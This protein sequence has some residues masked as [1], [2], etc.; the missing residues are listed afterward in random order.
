[1]FKKTAGILFVCLHCLITGAAQE[2]EIELDPVT[3]TSS[4]QQTK[5]SRTGRNILVIKGD[6]LINTPVHTIDDLLRYIPGIEVQARGP[7]GA[8]S[9]FTLRGGTFQ[10]VLV[11]LDGVRINDPNT[12]HF[13]S[14]L[15]IAPAEIERIEVLKGGSSAIYGSDAVGGVIHIISK[16]FAAKNK[17]ASREFVTQATVGEYDLVNVNAGGFYT[18][19]KTAVGGGILSNHTSGQ[20]QRGARGYVHMNSASLSL[21]HNINA[22]WQLGL[23]T[24]YDNRDFSAQ[25]FYTGRKVDTATEQVKSFWNQVRLSYQKSKSSFSLNAGYKA[26]EDNYQFNSVSVPN[27]NKSRLLQA[28]GVYEH[29]FSQ[30]TIVSTGIQY[31]NRVIRSNDRGN[32][33]V[34]QVAGFATINQLIGP[35]FQVNPA[36]R[37]DWHEL[38]GAELVPQINASYRLQSLQLRSSAG[39]TIRYADFTEQFNNYNKPPF[40][41]SGN[42]IGNPDLKAERSL[43]YEAGLDWYAANSFRFSATYFHRDYTKLIDYVLTPYEQ[44]PRKDNLAPNGSFYLASNISEVMTKGIEADIQYQKKLNDGQSL[45]AGLGIVVLESESNNNTPSLYVSSH[46]K[47]LANF[48]LTYGTPWFS[49]SANGLYKV[50]GQQSQDESTSMIHAHLSRNYF[51][52]NVRGEVKL[53]KEM[54]SIFAQADNIL[55]ESYSDLLGSQMPGRWLMGGIRISLNK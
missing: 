5:S 22:N 47:F 14:Y 4:L 40:V 42:R 28:L 25:N 55:N 54:V 50:R 49:L 7:L 36:L 53:V 2:K 16:S 51:V 44:M 30:K 10:Q 33:Q 6:Q 48:S 31:Q 32:H 17:P 18:N 9:D 20:R 39:K 43:S 52:A 35:S 41:G 8:Q 15:P 13:S 46:A 34:N 24:A 26:L 19:G 11:I 23:R 29:R 27:N 38:G 1:M 3:I 21:N 37:F 12:G 45:L